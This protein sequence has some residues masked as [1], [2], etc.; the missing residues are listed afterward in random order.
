MSESRD[1]I[2]AVRLALGRTEP[3]RSPPVPPVIDERITRLVL[4]D[5]GL[6]ELFAKTARDNK[7]GVEVTYPE[8]AA[9]KLIEFLKGRGVKTIAMSHSKLLEQL[10]IASSLR[11]AGL[12]VRLWDQL[13]LD[14]LYDVDCG[15]TDVWAAVAEVGALVIR[16]SPEHGRAISLVPPIHVAILEPKN[17]VPDLVDLFQK[18]PADG[19][20]KFVIITG[21]SKTADIEMNLVTGVHGPGVLHV[22]VLQ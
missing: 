6:P 10:E 8:E 12:D 3:I 22:F 2:E 4:T 16:G 21:P 9:T 19:S 7:M 11:A 17:F 15:I 14:E 5:L 13:T 20:E 18:L 1:V